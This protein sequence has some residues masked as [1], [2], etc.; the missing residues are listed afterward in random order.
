MERIIIEASDLFRDVKA[1]GA[2]L[3]GDDL[4]DFLGMLAA[5]MT[6]HQMTKSDIVINPYSLIARREAEEKK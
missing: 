3:E 5:A 6:K 1:A 4:K 2:A